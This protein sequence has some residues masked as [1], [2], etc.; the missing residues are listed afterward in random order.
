MSFSNGNI[1]PPTAPELRMQFTVRKRRNPPAVIIVSLIDVLMV[2]LIFLMVTTTFRQQ[3]AVKLTLPESNHRSPTIAFGRKAHHETEPELVTKHSTS[4]PRAGADLFRPTRR[5]RHH[6]V[7]P[8]CA[9]PHK[10]RA[11]G[12]VGLESRADRA[13]RVRSE[14]RQ[15]VVRSR[16]LGP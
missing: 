1:G 9:R 8:R 11:I 2:V 4:R 5:L 6:V 3:P 13:F 7:G 14:S 12:P 16:L 15:G 10:R